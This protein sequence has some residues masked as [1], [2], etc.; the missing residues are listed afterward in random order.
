MYE[1][2]QEGNKDRYRE[3]YG[4]DVDKFSVRGSGIENG[5]VEKRG[6]TDILFLIIFFAFLGSLGFL[7]Y[8]GNANGN[9]AK[10]LAPINSDKVLCGL[11]SEFKDHKYLYLTKWDVET[12]AKMKMFDYG[13]CVNKC[14]SASTDTLEC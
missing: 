9:V 3:K 8:Y 10:L 13:V 2:G 6:C 12:I 1:G 11:S 7:T 4:D 14:P 5:L